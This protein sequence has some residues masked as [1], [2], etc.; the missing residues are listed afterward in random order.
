M[1]FK[2]TAGMDIDLLTK[3]E[4]AEVFQAWRAELARGAHFRHISERAE[5]AGGNYSREIGPPEGFVWSITQLAIAGGG[6]NLAADTFTVYR[7]GDTNPS[8]LLAS[9]IS[10]SRDW[11]VGVMVATGPVPF[12]VTGAGTGTGTDVWVNG[13]AVEV[14]DELA[15]MLL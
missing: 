3:A 1:R 12:I 5:L 15:W 11:D 10:R 4:V 14:P 9:G 13:S 2:L 7:G 6:I 8:R